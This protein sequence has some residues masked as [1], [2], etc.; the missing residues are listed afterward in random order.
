MKFKVGDKVKY[1]RKSSVFVAY[2]AIGI[3]AYK[4][5]D[6]WDVLFSNNITWFCLETSLV[7]IPS[8]NQQLLF[9]FM[10]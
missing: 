1:I 4:D 3:I 5:E 9:D 10:K 2:N 8:K 7:K 6:G